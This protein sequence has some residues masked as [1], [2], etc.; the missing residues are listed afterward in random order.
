MT[1]RLEAF[2]FLENVNRIVQ[3]TLEYY[4]DGNLLQIFYYF[5]IIFIW[6]LIVL[7]VVEWSIISHYF[8][9]NRTEKLNINCVFFHFC[10]LAYLMIEENY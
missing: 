5:P 4:V 10:S 6:F 7:Q 9:Y 1:T 3:S 8:F 2:E